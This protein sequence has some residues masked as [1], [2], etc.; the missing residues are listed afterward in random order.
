MTAGCPGL[1][2]Y[3][4]LSRQP[5][6]DFTNAEFDRA[7]KLLKNV[8]NK[9]EAVCLA[10]LQKYFSFER[11]LAI[12]QNWPQRPG[13]DFIE[14]EANKTTWLMQKS[15]AKSEQGYLKVLQ[16]VFSAERASALLGAFIRGD[17]IEGVELENEAKGA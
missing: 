13:T 14:A 6:T 1:A 8:P 11:A 16:E 7:I 12:Y 3:Q 10:E 9:T 5:G 2:L 15:K 17:L 4:N